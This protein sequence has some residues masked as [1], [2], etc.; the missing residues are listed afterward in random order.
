MFVV[1]FVLCTRTLRV[2]LSA[3]KITCLT[4]QFKKKVPIRLSS[5]GSECG[6]HS[7][8]FYLKGRREEKRTGEKER[9]ER[10][11]NTQK[12]GEKSWKELEAKREREVND[13]EKL[14]I[15]L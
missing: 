2:E 15:S 1:I 12:E 3:H 10:E 14:K 5:V 4:S 8:C 9:L 13:V 7:C 11:S 6:V